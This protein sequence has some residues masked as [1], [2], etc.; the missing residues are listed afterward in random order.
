MPAKKYLPACALLLAACGSNDT[1]KTETTIAFLHPFSGALA[2]QALDFE[3]AYNLALRDIN[4]HGGIRN[5][6]LALDPR[7]TETDP[8]V[9]GE[10][11]QQVI[12]EGYTIIVGDVSSSGTAAILEK[13]VPAGVLTITGVSQAV[14][15]A[16]PENNKLFFRPTITAEVPATLLAERAATEGHSKI[17]VITS[18]NQ[19]TLSMAGSF[20]AAFPEQNCDSGACEIT[21]VLQYDQAVDVASFDFD[22]LVAEALDSGADGLMIS[23]YPNDGVELFEAAWSAGYHG[24]LYATEATGNENVSLVL[25]DDVGNAIRWASLKP[26]ENQSRAYMETAWVD[27]G[28]DM[29]HLDGPALS[30]YDAMFVLGLAIAHAGSTNARAV[31]DSLYEVANPP[32]EVIY[33]GEWAKAAELIA[34][35]ED[36]QY[37]GVAS[38]VD[39]DEIGNVYFEAQMLHYVNKTITPM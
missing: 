22:S 25:P 35:G 20:Q 15:L 8:V 19:Y 14:P 39:F 24:E 31:S 17:A 36:I 29:S 32:G 21:T 4:D 27:A 34:A 5:S 30:C 1:T 11:A 9:A 10:V 6:T 2:G 18:T 28:G 13:A 23:S 7:D 16:K 33:A 3:L 26:I 12:D 37:D 38:S